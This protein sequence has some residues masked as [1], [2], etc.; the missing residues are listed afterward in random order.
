M[1]ML[2][3][4]N[5]YGS[6]YK[7]GACYEVDKETERRWIAN[8]IAVPSE[9]EAKEAPEAVKFTVKELRGIARAKGVKGYGSMTKAELERVCSI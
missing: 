4:T 8:G 9:P 3:T 1:R 6:L 2:K 5:H 7:Q